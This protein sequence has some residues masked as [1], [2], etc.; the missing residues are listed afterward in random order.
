MALGALSMPALSGCLGDDD[1]EVP[2]GEFNLLNHTEEPPE[3]SIQYNGE[4]LTE[5]N[6]SGIQIRINTGGSEDD[7]EESDPLLDDWRPPIVDDDDKTIQGNPGHFQSGDGIRF[8]WVSADGETQADMDEI[9][10]P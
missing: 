2:D 3:I 6:S 8:V 7:D 10:I 5:E 9:T 1:V 4:E